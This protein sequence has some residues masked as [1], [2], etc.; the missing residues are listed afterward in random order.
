MDTIDRKIL[1]T[2]QEDAS[3]SVAEIGCFRVLARSPLILTL[4]V[5]IISRKFVRLA[6][7]RHS[8]R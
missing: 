1:L 6:E 7:A 8:S 4:P 2:L 5:L 3:L